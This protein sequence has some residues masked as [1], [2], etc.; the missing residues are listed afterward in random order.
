MSKISIV[1][2]H[3]V[4]NIK[5]SRYPNIKGLEYELF[6]E[7]IEW[8]DKNYQFVTIEDIIGCYETGDKLPE[9]AML[10]TFDDGYIDHYTYC[11]PVLKQYHIQGVFYIPGKTF[12]EKKLLDVNKIHFILACAQK[13]ELYQDL[14]ALINLNREQYRLDSQEDLY[15][16][17]AVKSRWDDEKTIF[18]KRMLQTAL[19]E[20]LRNEISSKLFQKYVGMDEEQFAEELY[21]NKD[22][23]KFMKDCGMYIGLHGY[24]HYWLA[25]LNHEKMKEDTD[26]ALEAMSG[27]VD[28]NNWILNYPYGSYNDDVI[29]YIKQAGCKL[30][31][32]TEVGLAD[33][34]KYDRYL[35]PRLN[36]N[37]YPPKGQTYMKFR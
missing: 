19:P 33:T 11:L 10:L 9:N 7:Q 20:Q 12:T 16:R 6:K 30:S 13:E 26:R 23:I 8:M 3:Y 37:D 18:I 1:M 22:Q 34:E 27:I 14:V 29:T 25:N 32:T 15:Q 5:S 36:T 21:M 35:L 24:D 31:M 2:Y 28:Q 4:R 17:Y